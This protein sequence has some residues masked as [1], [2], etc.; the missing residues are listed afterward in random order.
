MKIFAYLF[1]LLSTS[2]WAV[3]PPKYLSVPEWKSCVGTV[4]KGSAQ[5]ICLPS[6]KPKDCLESSWKELTAL[7]EI[8]YCQSAQD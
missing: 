3:L 4:T 1:L 6:Q 7:N 2:S 5:F 8:E